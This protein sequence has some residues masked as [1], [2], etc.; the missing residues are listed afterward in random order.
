M[1]NYKLFESD[2]EKNKKRVHS[3]LGFLVARWD[4]KKSVLDEVIFKLRFDPVGNNLS[5]VMK[6]WNSVTD[7]METL[8]I[9]FFALID[10]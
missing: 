7:V 8:K 6:A 3:S 9:P 2:Q 4:G 10:Y 5:R 1:E